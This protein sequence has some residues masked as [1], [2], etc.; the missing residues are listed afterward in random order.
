[1]ML[2]ILTKVKIRSM[3]KNGLALDHF[4]TGFT[5]EEMNDLKNLIRF[6]K[7]CDHRK[8]KSGKDSWE[9]VYLS[10]NTGSYFEMIL[11][12]E[13]YGMG[14]AV[15]SRYLQYFDGSKVPSDFPKLKWRKNIRYWRKTKK[16]W[17]TA[18]SLLKTPLEKN[19]SNIFSTWIM[20]YHP[21]HE[22]KHAKTIPQS[23]VERFHRLVV[24]AGQELMPM[25]RYHTQWLPGRHKFRKNKI[26]LCIPSKDGGPFR[27]AIRFL[28]GKMQPRFV[29]LEMSLCPDVRSKTIKMRSFRLVKKENGRLVLQR[30]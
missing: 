23:N 27:I 12:T 4:Y 24:Q 30:R 6:S 15:S 10:S 18:I 22:K 25:I 14:I 20:Q 29:S 5:H 2:L 19:I 3:L 13:K 21:L 26:E 11:G 9:G 8:I 7:R 17:F 28:K 16:K 1:M